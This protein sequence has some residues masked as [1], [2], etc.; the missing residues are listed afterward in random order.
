[1]A[2]HV[3]IESKSGYDTN[4]CIWSDEVTA[5]LIDDGTLDTV[6][7]IDLTKTRWVGDQSKITCRKLGKD[8][9]SQEY[10]AQWRDPDT[11]ELSAEGVFELGVEV[12]DVLRERV[13]E[14]QREYGK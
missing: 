1:M 10:A 14:K 9:F 5:H 6:I 13:E 11:G 3:V 2:N 4:N 8:R 12:A 7:E